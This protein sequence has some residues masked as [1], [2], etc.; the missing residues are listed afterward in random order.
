MDYVKLLLMFISAIA[1]TL[2]YVNCIRIGFQQKTYC[3]PLWALSL[4]FTWEIWHG[5]FDLQELGPQLQ[6][7][8]NLIWALFDVTILYTFFRFGMRYFPKNLNSAW[9]Y[10]WGISSLIIS[11]LV[12]FAFVKEFGT[13]MGGGYAAFLQNLLMSILFIIM[14]QKRNG[15]EGQSLTIAY[16]KCLGTLAPTILF[17]IIG[18]VTMN[19]PNRFMLIIGSIIFAI[20]IVYIVMLSRLRKLGVWYGLTKNINV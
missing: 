12:Q 19:G 8:I 11:F 14:L 17:G 13:I 1:W 5:I 6:V 10:T 4:N 16:G 15:T 2:V 20:D 3:I 7:I 18:S 9:F